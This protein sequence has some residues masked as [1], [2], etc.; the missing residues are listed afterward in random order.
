MPALILSVIATGLIFVWLWQQME[1]L[2]RWLRDHIRLRRRENPPEP[3][4][5]DYTTEEDIEHGASQG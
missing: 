2:P 3:S 4:P 5:A 1:L